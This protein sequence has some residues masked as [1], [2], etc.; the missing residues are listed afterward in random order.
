MKLTWTNEDGAE[1]S[2][3]IP[4]TSPMAEALRD[5][6]NDKTVTWVRRPRPVRQDESDEPA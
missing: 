6:E 3:D 4:D 2:I 1:F 5:I